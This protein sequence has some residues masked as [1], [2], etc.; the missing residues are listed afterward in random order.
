MK[1][2]IHSNR[3]RL[4]RSAGSCA[5]TPG[6]GREQVPD[7][8]HD[9]GRFFSCRRVDFT[10]GRRGFHE[11]IPGV[12]DAIRSTQKQT[13]PQRSFTFSLRQLEFHRA[14]ETKGCL[15]AEAR[16]YPKR[17]EKNRC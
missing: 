10:N 5:E 11:F 2:V 8:Q 3:T 15:F 7:A 16:T 1:P 17:T 6:D 12:V 9:K 4:T 14:P 13:S